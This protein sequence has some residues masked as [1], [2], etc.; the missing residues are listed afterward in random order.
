MP[1]TE[2]HDFFFDF[3]FMEDGTTIDPISLGMVASDG[4]EL[5]IEYDFEPDKAN[6]FVRDKV[7]PH[8]ESKTL[9]LGV[10]RSFAAVQ[11]L[12]FVKAHSLGKCVRFWGHYVAYDWV[13]LAQHWGPMI[14]LPRPMPW[15]AHDLIV[16][17][18]RYGCDKKLK[19]PKPKDE[20]HALADARWNREFHQKILLTQPASKD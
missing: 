20:H 5:Y 7:F 1:K 19:P 4:H 10:C 18:H 14:D 16:E 9:G 11:I 2:F 13:C 17:W 15:F 6:K 8:L 3:E 12:E